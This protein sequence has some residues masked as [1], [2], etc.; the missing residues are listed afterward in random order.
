MF[1]R[2][3]LLR[4]ALAV[5][6][7]IGLIREAGKEFRL[8]THEASLSSLHHA[9]AATAAADP[10]DAGP[11]PPPPPMLALPH[12]LPIPQEATLVRQ[13]AESRQRLEDLQAARVEQARQEFTAVA[14]QLSEAVLRV[15][16]QQLALMRRQDELRLL[17]HQVMVQARGGQPS[18]GAGAVGL[19]AAVAAAAPPAG[20][21]AG[22]SRRQGTQQD[23]LERRGICLGVSPAAAAAIEDGAWGAVPPTPERRQR[24]RSASQPQLE[25][26]SSS[27]SPGLKRSGVT[28]RCR[29]QLGEAVAQK[30]VL[31]KT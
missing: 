3:N 30:C 14:R 11:Q 27:R 21:A 24:H 18:G 29:A 1:L 28:W 10:T 5:F 19:V 12:R 22:S 15:E 25:C 6:Q 26:S 2:R 20:A 16:Q 31:E 4:R 7:N 23:R 17:C 9:A 8:F 13:L